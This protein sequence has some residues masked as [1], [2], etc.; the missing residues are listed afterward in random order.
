MALNLFIDTN[1]FLAFY[2]F[3]SEDLE[4]LRKLEALIT[5]NQICLFLPAQVKDEF[6]RNRDA[7]IADAIKRLKDQKLNFEFPQVCKD[8][9]E[10]STLRE[11]QKKYAASHAA[12]V[13]NVLDSAVAESLKADEI[14]RNLFPLAQSL[15]TTD[16]L[17]ARARIRTELGKPPGKKGSLGDAINW[18][19][20]LH[21]VPTDEPLHFVTD[22]RDYTSPLDQG[23]FNSFLV[24]EWKERKQSK[25]HHYRQLSSFLAAMLP[26]IKLATETAKDLLIQKMITSPSFSCTHS[27]VARL[28][29][30][31]EFTVDQADA[32]LAAA[33][34]NTQVNWIVMDRDVRQ[35]LIDAIAGREDQLDPQLLEE[36]LELI[37]PRPKQL[38]DP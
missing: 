5:G 10:Y 29:Q 33:V 7:K 6:R 38:E 8:Y 23:L 22:D 13:A 21:A 18:E 20:L 26:Q 12:L 28:R 31:P 27:V 14:I 9:A 36:V 25:L 15:P 34:N 4:E 19:S 2:H 17:T 1:I 32:I 30:F 24:S 16:E 3:S 11:L 37:R 35:L